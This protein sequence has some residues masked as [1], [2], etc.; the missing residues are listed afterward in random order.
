MVGNV[1]HPI[2]RQ[3]Q[4]SGWQKSTE[5]SR[6]KQSATMTGRVLS[7]EHA[8]K[9]KISNGNKNHHRQKREAEEEQW[10]RDGKEVIKIKS[11]Y[12]PPGQAGQAHCREVPVER[13]NSIAMNFWCIEC[14]RMRSLWIQVQS[15][16]TNKP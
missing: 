1:S 7:D 14:K 11:I 10:K 5:S 3:K 6:A 15:N 4:N 12:C 9:T 8:A 16:T 2:N 13:F